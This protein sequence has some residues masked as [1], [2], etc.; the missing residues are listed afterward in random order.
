MLIYKFLILSLG[1]F[2]NAFAGFKVKKNNIFFHIVHCC[3]SFH[4]L[5]EIIFF[6]SCLFKVLLLK[7]PVYFDWP[8]DPVCCGWST[9]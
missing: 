8:V 6:C 5:P 2:K 1:I 3:S 7:H 9:A 4:P